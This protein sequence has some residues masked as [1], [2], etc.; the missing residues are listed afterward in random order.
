[1]STSNGNLTPRYLKRLGWPSDAISS[2]TKRDLAL[3]QRIQEANL[4]NIPFENLSQH[5]CPNDFATGESPPSS[6]LSDSTKEAGA[7][8]YLDQDKTA[9]KILDHGRG[10]F[11]YEVNLLLAAWLEELGYSVCRVPCIVFG[12]DICGGTQSFDHLPS[13]VVL[14]VQCPMQ[15]DENHYYVEVGLG[16]P[17]IHPLLFE[18]RV[19]GK[20]QRTAEGLRSRL[21]YHT[22]KEETVVQLFLCKNDKWSPQLQWDYQASFKAGGGATIG[23]FISGVQSVLQ[24]TSV[25]SQKLICCLLKCDCKL[26]LAGRKLKVTSPRGLWLEEDQN[27]GGADCSGC[28]KVSI[29]YLSSN[30][31]GRTILA[32]RFGIPMSSTEGLDLGQSKRADAEIWDEQ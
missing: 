22:I 7:N 28:C 1:M 14:I 5:G 8:R 16:E 9:T 2:S 30:E 23:D 13:H 31:E 6:L 21:E 29:E 19:F 17:P 12:G 32:E 18:E 24:P 10:G 15:D 27:P 26:T 11:C 20:E 3:L 25:F 4:A